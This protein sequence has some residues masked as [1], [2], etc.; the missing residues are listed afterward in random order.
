MEECKGLCLKMSNSENLYPNFGIFDICEKMPGNDNDNLNHYFEMCSYLHLEPN[1]NYRNNKTYMKN[2]I[3]KAFHK[4]NYASMYYNLL[5]NNTINCGDCHGDTFYQYLAKETSKC[6][7]C[8]NI[9]CIPCYFH[10]CP[11]CKTLVK[12]GLNLEMRRHNS[13]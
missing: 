11:Y 2:I 13:P 4:C 8:N 12:T 1:I 10:E 7:V 5:C 3:C 6:Y 9:V